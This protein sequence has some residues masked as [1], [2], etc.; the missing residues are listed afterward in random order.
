LAQELDAT[1]TAVD[2]LPEFLQTLNTKAVTLGLEDRIATLCAPMEDLPLA[3]ESLDVIWSEGA[4]YNMG[5]EAG[6][7]SWHRLLKRGGKL[8]VSEITWLTADR[9]GALQSH[10]DTEYPEVALASEKLGILEQHRYCPEA[11]F[12]LPRHCWI[13]HYFRP[14][15]GRFHAFL[16]QYERENHSLAKAIVEEQQ[17]EIA[18]YEQYQDY[19]SYGFYIA[20]KL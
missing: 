19:F 15:Q 1:L 3:S 6:I 16:A 14:L 17:Q 12:F 11:Y 20:Q 4:I 8:I 13:D 2:F 5:F 10:W 7:S 18:L 9:P